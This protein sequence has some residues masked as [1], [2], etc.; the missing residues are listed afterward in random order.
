MACDKTASEI[1]VSEVIEKFDHDFSTFA[2]AVGKGEFAFWIGSGISRNAPNLGDLLGKAIEF[3]RAESADEDANGRFTTALKE[4]LEIAEV[5]PAILNEQACMPFSEWPNREAM[6]TKLWSKYSEVLDLRVAGEAR[7]YILWDAIDIRRAFEDPPAPAIEHLCVAALIL[8]GTV[9]N[10]ASANWDTFVEQAVERLV[11]NP[12]NV[13]QVIV[14]PNHLRNP[15]GQARLL[16]FHGCIR[17]AQ[18][19]PETF[20]DYLTGSTTQITEWPQN[21]LFTAVRNEILSIATNQKALVMGLSIQD[22]NL[23][24]TFSSAKQANPWPWPC[25]PNAPGYVFCQDQLTRGQKAVL[26]LVYG[27]S[28]DA[29]AAEISASSHLRAWPEQVLIALLLQVIFDKLDHLMSAWLNGLGKEGLSTEL[30]ASLKEC[31]KFG[32]SLAT[33]DRQAF[34]SH[35]LTVWPRL[36]SLFRRGMLPNSGAYEPVS[37][38][39]LAQIAGDEI[40][41]DSNL[42]KLALGL[43]LLNRGRAEDIWSFSVVES[44]EIEGGSFSVKGTWEGA[45]ARPVFIVKSVTEAICLEKD[46]AFESEGAIVLHSDDL[47]PQL[48][49]EGASAR[50]PRSSPGRT[51]SVRTSHISLEQL[52][53]NSEGVD[54]LSAEFVQEASI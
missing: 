45:Q 2:K 47:W 37:A 34:F 49:P 43:C 18:D 19:D 52:V 48:R 22:Q 20:R 29:N 24:Q 35:A 54:S 53:Q 51:S 17:H 25:E 39:S 7:D 21:P 6:V 16:K 50:T 42:G 28:Y 4:L 10:I 36:L 40:A 31:L 5:D 14:D 44:E 26:K 32:A 8:E 1:T 3:L 11:G 27:E 38:T 46:G 15:P 30:S 41:H 23:H 33:D 13:L 9:R 12:A